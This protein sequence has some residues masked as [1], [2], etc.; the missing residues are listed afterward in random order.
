MLTTRTVKTPAVSRGPR[1]LPHRERLGRCPDSRLGLTVA[2]ATLAPARIRRAR[3][4]PRGPVSLGPST[5]RPDNPRGGR[6]CWAVS[7]PKCLSGPA[8]RGLRMRAPSEPEMVRETAEPEAERSQ[9]QAA[10]RSRPSAA[11]H[12]EAPDPLPLRP[13]SGASR[14]QR[15]RPT[16]ARS[17]GR[18]RSPEGPPSARQGGRVVGGHAGGKARGPATSRA[19]KPR[20]TGASCP[21]RL[22]TRGSWFAV[23]EPRVRGAGGTSRPPREE[24]LDGLAQATDGARKPGVRTAWRSEGAGA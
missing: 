5:P 4:I 17:C 20:K 15:P 11:V 14:T 22:Q 10:G 6:G 1:P 21:S 9:R 13:E 23:V 18:G 7:L 8:P 3:R 19:R 16:T 2:G 24:R 12:F